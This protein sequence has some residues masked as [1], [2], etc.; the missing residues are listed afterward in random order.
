MNEQNVRQ[1]D[2]KT[3]VKV[4]NASMHCALL[5]ARDKQLQDQ[6]TENTIMKTI[7]YW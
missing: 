2:S 4:Y 6:K 7:N 5:A 1:R 3:V